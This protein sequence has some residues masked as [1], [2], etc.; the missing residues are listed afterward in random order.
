MNA[1]TFY[2][3]VTVKV[4][5]SI[6]EAICNFLFELGATGLA[7]HKDRIVAYF[8]GD[9]STAL[10][11]KSLNSFLHSLQELFETDFEIDIDI[12]DI[13][14]RDWREEWK[15][16]LTSIPVSEK[17]IIKPSWAELPVDV[18]PCVIELDPEMAF[19]SGTH[20]T[21]Q[22]ML[23]SIETHVAPGQMVFD[24]GTGTGILAIAAL[25]LGAGRVIGCDV[26][27]VAAQTAKRNVEKN[28][29]ADRFSVYAGPINAVKAEFDLILANVNRKVILDIL[30][31]I[32]ERTKPGGTCLLSGILNTEEMMIRDACERQNLPVLSV[33]YKD[34][35][36]T[37]ETIKI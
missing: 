37:L 36:L 5:P 24:V 30:F 28:D 15:K 27:P 31:E 12:Q 25:K 22:L 26:D 13:P 9:T 19:G 3:Q 14:S 32:S 10:L 17:I 8:S 23:I 11:K 18:P 16:D 20:A 2:K 33:H 21:T 6:S 7:E 1:P 4:V 34:E 35:W 29:V